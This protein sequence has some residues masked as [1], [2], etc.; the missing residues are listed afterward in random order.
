MLINNI[1]SEIE[2]V[3]DELDDILNNVQDDTRAKT[4]DSQDNN[5]DFMDAM[6]LSKLMLQV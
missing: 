6:Q 4:S 3:Q 2:F 1:I 5:A